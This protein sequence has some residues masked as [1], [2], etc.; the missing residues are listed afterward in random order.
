MGFYSN[1]Q[2]E[3]N[4]LMVEAALVSMDTLAGLTHTPLSILLLPY[5]IY[6]TGLSVPYSLC[7]S[8][9]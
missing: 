9:T 4:D 6:V 7:I 3:A 5:S 2:S 8:S 1:L